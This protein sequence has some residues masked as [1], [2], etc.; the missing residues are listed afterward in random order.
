MASTA[1]RRLP[2]VSPPANLPDL[3]YAALR[4]AIVRG[5]LDFGQPCARRN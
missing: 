5:R 2:S 1:E 3:A 4:E